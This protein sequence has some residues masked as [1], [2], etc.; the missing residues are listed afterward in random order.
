[1]NL[2]E[3]LTFQGQL[4]R[5]KPFDGIQLAIDSFPVLQSR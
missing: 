4:V 2:H 5:Y 3:D 1:M